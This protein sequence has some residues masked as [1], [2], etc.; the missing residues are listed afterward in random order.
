MEIYNLV[1]GYNEDI[2]E[3]YISVDESARDY[4]ISR[5]LYLNF[6]VDYLYDQNEHNEVYNN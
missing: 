4:F 6:N 2:T 3:I 1:C 5:G